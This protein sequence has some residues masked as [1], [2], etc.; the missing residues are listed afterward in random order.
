MTLEQWPDA[1]KQEADEPAK[2]RSKNMLDTLFEVM[3]LSQLDTSARHADLADVV[4]P[5]GK[6][7]IWVVAAW[8]RPRSLRR[9]LRCDGVLPAYVPAGATT[10]QPPMTP[11]PSQSSQISCR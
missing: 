8:P 3:D 6:I 2:P 1:P 5:V 11:E 10:R 4:R 9:A 7:P